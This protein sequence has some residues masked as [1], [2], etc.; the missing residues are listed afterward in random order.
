[1]QMKLPFYPTSTKLINPTLGF[2]EMNGIVQYLHIGE[3]IYCHRKDDL[4]SYRYI[5]GNLIFNKLC[6]ISELARALGVNKRNIERYAKSV[7]ENGT[8]H[9]FHKEDRRGQCHKMTPDIVEKAQAFLD[10]GHSQQKTANELSVSE[11]SIR[12]H[13]RKGNLKK[14]PD[15]V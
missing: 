4:A 11:S 1:M 12:Y 14:K 10:L 6:T 8:S 2:F 3:P 13:F 15:S 9:F 7:Q 5:C